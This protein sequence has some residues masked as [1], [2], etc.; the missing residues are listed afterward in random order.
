MVGQEMLTNP[1]LLCCD[2]PTSG[3]DSTTACVV[4]EALRDLAKA[5][6]VAVVASIHEP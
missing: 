4:V 5:R 1:R 6:N 2:E 3:L